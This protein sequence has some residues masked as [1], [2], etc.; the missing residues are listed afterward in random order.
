MRHRNSDGPDS[1]LVSA[2]MGLELP[3]GASF[4]PDPQHP[5]QAPA[6]LHASPAG[7]LA[8]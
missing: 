2:P 6:D 5:T 8:R 7:P 4:D 3:P 1:G